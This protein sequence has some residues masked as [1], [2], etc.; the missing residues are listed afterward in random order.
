MKTDHIY[1]GAAYYDEYLPYERIEQ[2]MSMM[3]KAGMNV[4]RIAES[5]W[6][7][8]EPHEGVY[9]FTHLDKMLEAAARHK[10]NVI[11]GTP[12]YAIPTWLAK[13][14][15]DILALTKDGQELY[16]RRQNMDI[17][18]PVYLKYA[19]N[20][21]RI[22][23]EH[24]HHLPHVIGYQIDNETHHYDT[25]G[26]RVQAMFVEYIKEK[27]PDI[28]NFNHEFGL[29]YWSNRINDWSDFPDVRGTINGSLAAEFE[30]F[31]R[32]LVTD[33]HHWQAKIIEEYRRPDQFVTHNF[34]FEWHN[35]SFGLQPDANSYDCAS[36]M[37]VAGGDIYHLSQSRLTGAEI[38]VCGNIL[39]SLKQDNYLILE[40]QAQ[41]NT[42]WL[43]YP[44]QLRLCAYSHI[45]NG[46]N[47]VMYWHWHS[48]HNAIESYWKGVLSHDFS[49]NE[50][51]R[52]ASVVGQELIRFGDRLKNLKKENDTALL[53]D[54]E[55]L[56]GLNLFPTGSLGDSSYNTIVRW[57]ADALHRANI[58]FDVV[59]TQNINLEKYKLVFVPSLYSAREDTLRKL[60]QYVAFGGHLAVTFR[61]G[62]TDE[63]IKIR[64]ATQPYLL[65]RCLGV[66]YDQFTI[67]ENVS[68]NC[69]FLTDQ[70]SPMVK[71][72]MELVIPDTAHSLANYRH[73]AWGKYAAIT[74][75]HWKSGT[76]YYLGC[77]FDDDTLDEFI[78]YIAKKAEVS[79]SNVK[80][81]VII[82]KGIN[83]YGHQIWYYL[84]YSD[85]TQSVSYEGEPGT[86]L[87]ENAQINHGEQL[88]L[89]PWD[90]KIIESSHIL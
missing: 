81:P 63:Y 56:T 33:F 31:Q 44:G 62:F 29:D 49:E 65:N 47:S 57:I 36:C 59:F 51:Y 8:L 60:E 85:N 55:S 78:S 70:K 2:D 12:T 17:T 75:N 66:H 26:P 32:K 24:V 15:D 9:D 3:S 77:F 54:H 48:I 79:F 68:L 27:F 50:T 10:I 73:P 25:S 41:G 23:L 43:P 52:E 61:S 13:K 84:N 42:N 20:I 45:A 89:A 18:S 58:E 86:L 76:A 80:F 1:F 22:L 34:D 21:I 4:I 16:G 88:I 71:E 5:T 14:S 69:S 90:V 38:T 6:S 67:P 37:T 72:W 28:K 19:E 30:K 11:I 39:R 7:T 74:E 64:S 40:T 53:L 87:F 82:K 83:D 46:A 35:Y